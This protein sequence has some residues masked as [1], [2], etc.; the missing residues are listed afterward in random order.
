MKKALIAGLMLLASITAQADILCWVSGYTKAN[1]TVVAPYKRMQTSCAHPVGND[2]G[3]AIGRAFVVL[4]I[5]SIVKSLTE[6]PKY[7]AKLQ[8]TGFNGDV[9]LDDLEAIPTYIDI[10]KP[11][12][13]DLDYGKRFSSLVDTETK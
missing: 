10:K 9:D 11:V 3:K 12:V 1:G 8:L 7:N 6:S 2:V 13:V 5:V 4:G